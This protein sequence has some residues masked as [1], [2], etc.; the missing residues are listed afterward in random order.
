M[1]QRRFN[2]KNIKAKSI[3][4]SNKKTIQKMKCKIIVKKLKKGKSL[5]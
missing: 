2:V 3:G 5:K 4:Y 1:K